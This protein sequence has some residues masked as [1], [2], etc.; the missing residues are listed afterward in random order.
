[1]PTNLN[2]FSLAARSIDDPLYKVAQLLFAASFDPKQAAWTLAPHKD[3]VIAYCF[4]ILDMEE[5]NG[6]DAPGDGYAPANAALLLAEW[7]VAAAVPRFW[8]ILRDDTHSRPGKITF[9]SNTVLLALEAWGP[10]LIEDTLRFAETVEGRLLATMGAILSLNAQADPRV[11]PWLQARFEKAR[12]EELIQIWAHSLLL[13]DSQV[14]IPYLVARILNR[15]Q[16]SRKL[17]DALR[18][19][20]RNVRETGLP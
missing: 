16:Y 1:M 15:R 7:K 5:L 20:I 2:P 17:K 9:L 10:S 12:D 18:G 6:I 11:Y 14:A 4:D 3:A 13:A 8:R 19:L